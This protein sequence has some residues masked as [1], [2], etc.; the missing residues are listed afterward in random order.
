EAYHGLDDLFA[1]EF[2]GGEEVPGGVGLAAVVPAGMVAM[3]LALG[4]GEDERRAIE[5]RLAAEVETAEELG[6][7]RGDRDGSAEG[8]RTDRLVERSGVSAGLDRDIDPG[9]PGRVA[10]RQAGVGRGR[11]EDEI[12]TSRLGHGP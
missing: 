3:G 4:P 8:E 12:G 6:V 11:V 9:A 7:P 2:A 10:D 1:V 5:V